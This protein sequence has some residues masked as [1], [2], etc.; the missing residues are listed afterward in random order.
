MVIDNDNET[1]EHIAHL[2]EKYTR[3]NDISDWNENTM[4]RLFLKIQTVDQNDCSV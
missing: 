2:T 4:K 1:N 3:D